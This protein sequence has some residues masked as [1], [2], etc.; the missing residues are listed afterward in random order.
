MSVAELMSA[1]EF[2]DR[3]RSEG[4]QRYHSRHTFNLRMHAGE[5]TKAELQRWVC[6]MSSVSDESY[7]PRVAP[8]CDDGM[9][10]YIANVLTK[11]GVRICTNTKVDR[12]ESGK[13]T[14]SDG[15]IIEAETIVMATRPSKSR[16]GQGLVTFD[17]RGFNQR[18]EEVLYS[19]RIALM[20]GR[21]R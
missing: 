12:I 2:V 18:D 9:A 21:T 3:L 4:A 8:E 19:R 7:Y 16:P 17:H 15:D 13:V 10:E 1:G 11:R 20:L 6:M 5:L 14:L